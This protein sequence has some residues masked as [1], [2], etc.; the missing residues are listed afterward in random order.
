[1][2]KGTSDRGV[3]TDES[4]VDVEI[5]VTDSTA[6]DEGIDDRI[7]GDSRKPQTPTKQ[8]ASRSHDVEPEKTGEDLLEDLVEDPPDETATPPGP[9]F[10][11]GRRK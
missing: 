7:G 4:G 2:A 9:A 10:K 5:P 11:D 8:P 1:M 6:G 3:R